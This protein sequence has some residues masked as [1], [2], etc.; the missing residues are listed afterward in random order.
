MASEA[1][2]ARARTLIVDDNAR[3]R[4]CIRDLLVSAPDVKVV[5]EAVSG[6]DGLVKARDLDPDLVLMDVRMQG[7]SGLETTVQLKREMPHVRVIILT[8]YDLPEYRE[9]AQSSG[10]S[11]CVVKRD[12][13]E[14]LLPTIRDVCAIKS[15][16]VV[17]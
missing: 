12:L 1:T 13:P 16:T 8:S 11:G 15:V 4:R 3:L 7:S 10:A 14:A 2:M 6:P 17:S 9:A 5:G